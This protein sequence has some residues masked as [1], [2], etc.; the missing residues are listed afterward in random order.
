MGKV[1]LFQSLFPRV[2]EIA[3]PDYTRRDSSV[4]GVI[5]TLS[6][7]DKAFINIPIAE[8]RDFHCSSHVF[9]N[10]GKRSIPSEHAAGRG[11]SKADYSGDTRANAFRVG[12]P[13]VPFSVL[14]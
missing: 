10:L 9:E 2:L 4:S 7:V 8:A 5:R 1:A 11:H 14:F 6:S 12:C 3:Q 13:N